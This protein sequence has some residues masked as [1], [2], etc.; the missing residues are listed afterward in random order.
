MESEQSRNNVVLSALNILR[1]V[2]KAVQLSPFVYA[3]AYIVILLLYDTASDMVLDVLDDLFYVSP[4][5]IVINL[6]YS[7]ILKM[8]AWHKT[9]CLLPLIPEIANMSEEFPIE[10]TI[11]QAQ[12]I[13]YASAITSILFLIAAYKVFFGDGCKRNS[14]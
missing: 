9:A 7:R 1:R 11:S 10:F 8:C 14:V 5:V 12:I 13:N 2:K 4:V 3:F 6:V